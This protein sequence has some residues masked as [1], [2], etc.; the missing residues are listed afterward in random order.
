MNELLEWRSEWRWERVACVL[1]QQR[2]LERAGDRRLALA[3]VRGVADHHCDLAGLH[4]AR[5]ALGRAL[6]PLVIEP[7]AHRI[8]REQLRQAGPAAGAPIEQARDDRT[9]P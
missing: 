1:P 4:Q 7:V 6:A 8:E 9:E 5:E 2:R 3:G